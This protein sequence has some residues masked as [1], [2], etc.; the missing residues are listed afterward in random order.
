M[1]VNLTEGFPNLKNGKP[2]N[3][4]QKSGMFLGPEK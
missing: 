2:E 3:K 4:S 1:N